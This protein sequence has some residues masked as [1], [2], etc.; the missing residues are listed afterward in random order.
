MKKMKTLKHKYS[1]QSIRDRISSIELKDPQNSTDIKKNLLISQLR[2]Y[3]APYKVSPSK[4][5]IKKKGDD[6]R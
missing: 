3:H 2:S 4:L 6:S 5:N 1:S